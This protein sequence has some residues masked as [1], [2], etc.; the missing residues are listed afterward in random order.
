MLSLAKFKKELPTPPLPAADRLCCPTGE[1]TLVEPSPGARHCAKRS[2]CVFS[3][4]PCS[5]P[6]RWVLLLSPFY[7]WGSELRGELIHPRSL[8]R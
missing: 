7:R 5:H 6:M 2:T 3:C 4:N 8:S 1:G